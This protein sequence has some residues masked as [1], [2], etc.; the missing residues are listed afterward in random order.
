MAGRVEGIVPPFCDSTTRYRGGQH[1]VRSQEGAV[2]LPL[3]NAAGHGQTFRLGTELLESVQTGRNQSTW[4]FTGE[5][6]RPVSPSV[7]LSTCS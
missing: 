3:C 1:M 6:R 7:P 2:W 5:G 4:R